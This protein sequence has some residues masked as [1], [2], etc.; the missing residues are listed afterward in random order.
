MMVRRMSQRQISTDSMLVNII[1]H[2]SENNIRSNHG[3]CQT[4]LFLHAEQ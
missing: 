1:D 2:V 4:L 3:H